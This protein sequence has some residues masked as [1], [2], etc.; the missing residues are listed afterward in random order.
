MGSCLGRLE[1]FPLLVTFLYW[2]GEVRES[3]WLV[4][5]LPFPPVSFISGKELT[6]LK[7]WIQVE[8]KVS[9]SFFEGLGEYS[10]FH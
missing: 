4:F 9:L 3:S 5:S 10:C 1:A 8:E 6:G 2:E 7:D